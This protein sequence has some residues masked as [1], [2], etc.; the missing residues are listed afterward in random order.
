MTTYRCESVDDI[1][2]GKVLVEVFY[3]SD[4]TQVFR[5]SPAEFATHESE[6]QAFAECARAVLPDFA[7]L[8]ADPENHGWV[9][10]FGVTQNSPWHFAGIYSDETDARRIALQMGSGYEVHYGSHRLDTSDFIF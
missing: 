7:N 8:K 9:L 4:S 10:G 1:S 6:Q 5:V 3:P 2:S